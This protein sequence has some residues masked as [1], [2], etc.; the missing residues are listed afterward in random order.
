MG[1]NIRES[2]QTYEDTLEG[3]STFIMDIPLTNYFYKRYLKMETV[4]ILKIYDKSKS[5]KSLD[6]ILYLFSPLRVPKHS[7]SQRVLNE[8]GIMVGKYK[9]ELERFDVETLLI[10]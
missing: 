6:L 7:A 5:K 9:S 8:R 3:E 10:S 1:K 4:D 2:F